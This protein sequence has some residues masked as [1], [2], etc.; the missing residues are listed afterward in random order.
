VN[1]I[2]LG[3]ALLGLALALAGGAA[4]AQ[5]TTGRVTG[6]VVDLDTG[7]PLAGVTVIVQGPQ[8]EDGAI[9]NERGQYDFTALPV[10]IYAVRFYVANTAAGAQQAG[11]VVSAQKTVRVNARIAGA[12]QAMPQQLYVINGRPPAVDVGSAR[13]GTTFDADFARNVPNGN[14][15][16]DVLQKAPRTFVDASGN[17][18]IGG[19][20]GLENIYVVNGMNVTGIE[21]GNLEVGAASESGGTNLP[22]EFL[23]QIDVN[24]GGYQAE[25]GGAMGGVVNTVLKSGTNQLHGSV[26][27]T[28][29]PYWLSGDPRIISTNGGALGSVRKPDFDT[30]IGFELGGPI[31]KDKLFFW[32]GLAPRFRNTHVFR[33]TYAQ[34]EAKDPVTGMGTGMPVVDANGNPVT[35]ELTD[36]RARIDETRKVWNYAATVDYIPTPDHKLT[37]SLFGT[38]SFNDQMR[39]FLGL[40]ALANPDWSR[41]SL[42][43]TNTDATLHWTSKLFSRHWQIDA[44][45][46]LHAEY[47]NDRSPIDALNNRNQLEIYGA[48]LWDLE[49][50]PGCQP[51]ATGFQPCP[52]PYYHTGGFGQI[53]QDT[54]QRWMG[55]LKST[56]TF[57]AGGSHEVKYGWHI[58]QS[59]LD[60]TR[61]YSGPL[62]ARGLVQLYPAGMPPNFYTQTF[63]TLRPN[64][65]PTDFGGPGSMHPNTDLL[66]SPDYQ[67]QLTAHVKSL[68]NA[69]FLQEGWS[70][71]F[72][73]NL[74]V[75]VGARLELQKIYDTYGK[76]FL[77][78]DNL[79]PRLGAVYDPANDGRSKISVSYGRYFEAVPLNIA[80]RY[81][82]GE[83]FLG[84][85]NV[86]F[87][88]C[89]NQ[90]PYAW[91]GS[92]EWKN[93]PLPA[94]GDFNDPA[95]SFLGTNGK[96]YPLQA[97]LKGQYHNEIVATYEREIIEDLSVRL[98]YVHRWLG[99][100]IE[101]SGGTTGAFVL[102]NP[103][104]IPPEAITEAKAEVYDAQQAVN[105]NPKDANAASV[106]SAAQAKLKTL[107]DLT[108]V[109]KPERTYDALSITLAKRFSQ[110]WFARA[111]YTYSRLVGNYEG[112]FQTET[113]YPAP[114]G[115][116]AYDYV[117]LIPNSRGRL[118][119]D[120]PHLARVDGYYSHPV[121]TGTIVAG[122]S[123]SGQSGM[124]RNY[125]SALI[126]G[127][128]LTFLLPRGSAGRT[129]PVT[130]FDGHLAYRR[131]LSPNVNLEVFTDVFNL[132]NQQAAILVDDN[133]TLDAAAPIPNGTP[134]DLKFARNVA[135]QPLTKNANFGNPLTYQAPISARLGVRMTF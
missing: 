130:Q 122:L 95:A 107:Q 39:S 128:Q 23:T 120:R 12:A 56:H 103:G 44:L 93:C 22:L 33:L 74:T 9:T 62:G 67:D 129:P 97:H 102:A 47:L 30:S 3:A 96:D 111:S 31:I 71:E 82:G 41:E 17:V 99:T 2:R 32:V 49:H 127:Y 72:L 118:P 77:D 83:G 81:F 26:F 6:Q 38:P 124:P 48:N 21:L 1:S 13:V 116:N 134:Q 75:N 73:R 5:E 8:G 115:N 28:W 52:V 14:T 94:K 46:G 43:K 29:A 50:A 76:A 35:H 105:A 90:D 66:Y 15:Y 125:M 126:S 34:E 64:E 92:G 54:G 10:G 60:Q 88:G 121:G 7:A 19:S 65:F 119:N 87:D 57:D 40:E 25:F 86:P 131:P 42:T 58:E 69:F 109:P 79:A 51:T 108:N 63:F 68:S 106:L 27:G 85:G 110:N 11:V 104:D 89:A 91:N 16:G 100:I 80:A 132:F 37:L 117:E 36:W 112:L 20:T 98:D 78:T 101:D 18:S 135:G 4:R 123:F 55:E 133:Y 59:S 45:G 114:N 61:Y 70:P 84:R 113:L 53:T 24:A